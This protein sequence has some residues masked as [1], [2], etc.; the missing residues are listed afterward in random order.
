[1]ITISSSKVLFLV[2][3][4]AGISTASTFHQKSST[5]MLCQ[6][7][8]NGINFGAGDLLGINNPALFDPSYTGLYKDIA[9]AQTFDQVFHL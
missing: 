7:V 5:Q 4:P 6:G 9:T 3:V 8:A 2:A 1:M